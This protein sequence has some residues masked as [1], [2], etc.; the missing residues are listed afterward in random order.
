MNRSTWPLVNLN[1]FEEF[2]EMKLDLEEMGKIIVLLVVSM[3][4]QSY[5]LLLLLSRF[6]HVRLCAIP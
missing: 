3:I 4:N 1:F 6:S 2:M 5:C